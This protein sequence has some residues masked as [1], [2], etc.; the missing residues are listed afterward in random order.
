MNYTV[1]ELEASSSIRSKVSISESKKVQPIIQQK[2]KANT[3]VCHSYHVIL[4]SSWFIYLFIYF[5]SVVHKKS[6]FLLCDAQTEA[7]ENKTVN[8]VRLK[9]C[10]TIPCCDVP[11]PFFVH[12]PLV[13]KWINWLGVGTI[14]K[15]Q[16][17]RKVFQ[18]RFLT[19]QEFAL[20]CCCC[21]V[22]GLFVSSSSLCVSPCSVNVGCTLT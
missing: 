14:V 21:W 16:R 1:L 22:L 2:K 17:M 8:K 6:D 3:T 19:Y 13:Y 12:I 10:C 5:F 20:F 9:C 15:N 4:V 11:R 7:E 18:R